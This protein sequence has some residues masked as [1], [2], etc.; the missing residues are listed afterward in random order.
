MNNAVVPKYLQNLIDQKEGQQLDFKYEISDLKKIAR[1]LS[2]FANTCGG[3]LLIGVKDNGKIAGVRSDEE[4]YMIDAAAK[5]YCKPKIDFY[6]KPWQI[7]K[8]IVLEVTIPESLKK[9]HFALNEN[10]LWKAYIRVKDKVFV[11]RNV[12]IR[13]W[14]NIYSQSRKPIHIDFSRKE[15][16]LLHYLQSHDFITFKKFYTMAKISPKTAEDVLVDLITLNVLR[17]VYADNGVP[18]YQLADINQLPSN[19]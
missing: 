4:L 12:Q 10:G 19:Q 1:T 11:A 2:A 9:P 18:L 14:K 3:K 15:D 6:F 16:L 8:K 17:I 13:V 7:N 5:M